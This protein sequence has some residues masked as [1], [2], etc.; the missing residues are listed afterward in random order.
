ME[1]RCWYKYWITF[2]SDWRVLDTDMSTYMIIYS[3]RE[4]FLRSSYNFWVLSKTTTSPVTDAY[5]TNIITTNLPNYD[6]TFLT[7]VN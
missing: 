7:A 6:F 3:C 5:I 2:N 4:F 1:Y